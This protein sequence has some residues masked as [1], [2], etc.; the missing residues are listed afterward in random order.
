VTTI[1]RR[2]SP[3]CFETVKRAVRVG[4]GRDRSARELRQIASTPP[5]TS[6]SWCRCLGE[7]AVRGH[8]RRDQVITR[9][10]ARYLQEK[11]SDVA[12]VHPAAASLGSEAPR[13]CLNRLTCFGSGK[14]HLTTWA[15]SAFGSSIGQFSALSTSS[16]QCGVRY[17]ATCE[18]TGINPLPA[19]G[20]H[21][22]NV[23]Q[24]APPPSC[25]RSSPTARY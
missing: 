4:S 14:V 24:P 10:E 2:Q 6:N 22:V 1:R 16:R 17:R 9:A 23:G 7:A 3:C 13:V 25:Q 5:L 11:P 8:R 19:T 15:V 12:T 20:G 21:R 18:A